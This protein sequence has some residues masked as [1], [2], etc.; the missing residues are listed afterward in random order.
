MLHRCPIRQRT[1]EVITVRPYQHQILNLLLCGCFALSGVTLAAPAAFCQDQG[2][3]PT[4]SPDNSAKNKAHNNTADQ[5]SEATSDRILT[6]KIRQSLVADK[7]LS[8]M[9]TT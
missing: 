6:K 8:T 2:G 9:R 4:A 7:S 5:Q 1:N 3:A